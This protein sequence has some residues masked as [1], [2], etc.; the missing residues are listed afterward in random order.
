MAG[1]RSYPDLHNKGCELCSSSQGQAPQRWLLAEELPLYP[2]QE[3]RSES[4]THRLN[5]GKTL[6]A[7]ML[8]AALGGRKPAFAGQPKSQPP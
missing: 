1:A 5:C 8:L 6:H 7:L 3:E 4:P 2:V